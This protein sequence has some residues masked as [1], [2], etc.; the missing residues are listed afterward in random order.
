MP[1][2]T[3]PM[4]VRDRI[5]LF[6]QQMPFFVSRGFHYHTSKA[7]QV[8]PENIPFAAV[9]FIEETSLPDGDANIGDIRFRTTARY[10]ISVIVQN[11]DSVAAELILDAAMNSINSM[12]KNPDLY[13]WDG[14]AD[15]T[16]IQAFIRGAR[17]HQFGNIGQNNELPIAELRYDLT[18][19]L[20]VILFD[21]PVDDD[22]ITFHVETRYPGGK[23]SSQ[24]QQVTAQYDIPQGIQHKLAAKLFVKVNATV[25]H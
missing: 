18:V 10:G 14:G 19:D 16:K 21:P 17:S 6:I 8:Q 15:E 4:L 24:I 22:F 1:A 9:Y 25:V 13:N 3:Y 12:F 2:F 5:L 20:G 11:N 23:D 7:I